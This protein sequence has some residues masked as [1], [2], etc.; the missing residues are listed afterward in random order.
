MLDLTNWTDELTL[1]TR[2]NSIKFFEETIAPSPLLID[3]LKRSFNEEICFEILEWTG[4]AIGNKLH[5]WTL[6]KDPFISTMKSPELYVN[7]KLTHIGIRGVLFGNKEVN[8]VIKYF[9][10]YLKTHSLDWISIVL[11]GFR[12]TPKL[13][14]TICR[15]EL[16][17][18]C[19]E[20]DH[21]GF[22]CLIE[23]LEGAKL[24]KSS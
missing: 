15:D 3:Q 10:E 20:G 18:L 7:Q 2:T 11:H 13:N 24:K 16:I 22:Q 8:L 14:P 5:A 4:L 19:P 21:V 9:R 23:D 12:D 6:E 17:F 1:I